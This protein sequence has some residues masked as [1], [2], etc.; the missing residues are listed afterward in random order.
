MAAA[1]PDLP[2][3]VV[4]NKADLERVAEDTFTALEATVCLD[5][6]CGY[7]ECSARTG[8]GMAGLQTELAI[9]LGLVARVQHAA[10]PSPS[11]SQPRWLRRVRTLTGRAEAVLRSHLTDF[12]SIS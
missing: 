2:V 7:A 8:A 10:A 5:W 9:S 11:A 4:G 1:R 6:E 12:C 3:V